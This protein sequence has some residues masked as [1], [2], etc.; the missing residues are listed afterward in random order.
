MK[1]KIVLLC[2]LAA[3]FFAFAPAKT[4]AACCEYFYTPWG[5]S[6]GAGSSQ[7]HCDTTANIYNGLK[8]NI[9]KKYHTDGKYYPKK[10]CVT[11]NTWDKR[12]E[13]PNGK[14]CLELQ[15]PFP[16]SDKIEDAAFNQQF[17]DLIAK[18]IIRIFQFGIWI[19]IS[20]AIF[21]IMLA[22]FIWLI[23]AGNMGLIGKAKGYITNALYG[24]IV[25]LLA[26]IMLQT[27]NPKLVELKMPAL[28]SVTKANSK[29]IC[30]KDSGGKLITREVI[31]EETCESISKVSGISLTD[32]SCGSCLCG[33]TY[34]TLSIENRYC[35]SP[36]PEDECKKRELTFSGT[37]CDYY[38]MSCDEL[39]KKGE[40]KENYNYMEYFKK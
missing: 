9:E 10:E 34:N 21:M 24:L 26:F 27:I 8:E 22:G 39:V 1:G 40:L 32:T 29:T 20:L 23:S 19:A 30:C 25:A 7:E 6:C 2:I 28:N 38:T 17:S 3:G 36:Y 15:I 5:V 16:G 37:W 13:C 14:N 12:C 35:G 11:P 4:N 31:G 33:S 18:Y